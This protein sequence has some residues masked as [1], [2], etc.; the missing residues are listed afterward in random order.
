M[1]VLLTATDLECARKL[2]ESCFVRLRSVLL[3]LKFEKNMYTYGQREREKKC[4]T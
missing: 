4:V 3:N 2:Q 1:I